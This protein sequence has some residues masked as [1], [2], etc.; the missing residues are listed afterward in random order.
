MTKD[1][2]VSVSAPDHPVCRGVKSMHFASEEFYR[3]ILFDESAGKITP[4]LTV[5]PTAEKP[6]DEVV[7]WAFERASG[8]RS[9]F[10]TGPHFLSSF[11]NEDF[12][13]LIMNAILWVADKE[14]PQD[15]V[16]GGAA[17]KKENSR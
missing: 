9:F 1:V 7:A 15:G 17:E 8:G 3:R 10:C 11:D 6:S 2:P 12:R 5:G 13:R 4:I 14:V 16:H